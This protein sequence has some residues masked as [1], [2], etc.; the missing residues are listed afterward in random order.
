M[1]YVIS[2]T[3]RHGSFSLKVA[4][5]YVQI[6]TESGQQAELC[7][8]DSM[9]LA[10]YNDQVYRKGENTLRNYAHRIFLAAE[11]FVIV[12]PEYNGSFPGVM[13][14]LLDVCEPD[15]FLGKKFALV[16]VSSGRAGNLRGLDHL[17]DILH[18]LRAEVYSLKQPVS[19]IRQLTN[20]EKELVD[21]ETIRVLSA[22]CA[23]FLKF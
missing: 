2:A 23:G 1:I 12:A 5:K 17:T 20:Q 15:I 11:R 3:T 4:E 22:Q 16:G 13:K 7:S 8:L 18:F 6:L 19:R 10:E 14:V 9:P 21:D